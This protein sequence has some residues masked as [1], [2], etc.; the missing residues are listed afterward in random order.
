MLWHDRGVTKP[1][2]GHRYGGNRKLAKNFDARAIL[3]YFDPD[4][5]DIAVAEA[6]GCNR[7]MVNKWRNDKAFMIS[8][9]RADRMAIR[10][11]L[12]PSLVW[13]DQWWTDIDTQQPLPLD[14]S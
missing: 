10:I 6:L 13:G 2:N 3:P 4:A 12:H 14:G 7:A 11:G 9:W 1:R 8:C 5:D